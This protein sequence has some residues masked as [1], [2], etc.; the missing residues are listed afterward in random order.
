MLPISGRFR[1]ASMNWRLNAPSWSTLSVP[2][3]SWRMK[4]K[5]AAAPKPEIVGM[6]NGKTIASGICEHSAAS[7]P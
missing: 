6:L 3:R 4:L 2:L 1:T 5:P 7:A